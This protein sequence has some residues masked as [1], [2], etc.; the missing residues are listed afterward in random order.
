M[1]V[2]ACHGF[3]CSGAQ[4]V[5]DDDLLDLVIAPRDLAQHRPGRRVLSNRWPEALEPLEGG[6]SQQ[7]GVRRAQPLGVVCVECRVHRQNHDVPAGPFVV[8]V[9]RDDVRHDEF[10]HGY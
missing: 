8:A 9:Q 5:R 2:L 10:A 1:R 3:V 6:A 7:Q 4:A